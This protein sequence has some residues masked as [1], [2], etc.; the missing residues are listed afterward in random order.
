MDLNEISQIREEVN[1]KLKNL[2]IKISFGADFI[3][4]VTILIEEIMKRN[5]K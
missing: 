3:M 5:K 2:E 4:A 1:K